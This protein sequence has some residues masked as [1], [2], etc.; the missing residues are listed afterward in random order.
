MRH[1]LIV[2]M[3]IS[4]SLVAHATVIVPADLNE[5]S[6]DARMIAR[7]R[8]VAVDSQWADDRRTI[9]TRV[10]LAIETYL[11]GQLGETVQFRVP[12]GTVGRFRNVVIGAPQFVVGQRVI[13][14]LGTRGPSV[15]FVLGLSQGVFRVRQ[16][17]AG[18]WMVTPAPMP[19]VSHT[20]QTAAS[21]SRGPAPLDAF[22]GEI[23]ALV[24]GQLQ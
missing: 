2:M 24:E 9:E 23:R 1:I 7:G 16:D 20:A 4:S 12:G 11:K 6:K 19:G 10:T 17:P 22:E 18:A 5:L 21:V 13:V 14:F 8:V 3:L 15:P